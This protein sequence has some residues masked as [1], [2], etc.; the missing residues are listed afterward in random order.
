MRLALTRFRAPILPSSFSSFYTLYS[1]TR[2]GGLKDFVIRNGSRRLTRRR[3]LPERSYGTVT[4]AVG[5]LHLLFEAAE[6]SMSNMIDSLF[7]SMWQ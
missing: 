5:D 4:W 7:L 6:D 1:F 3:S 2:A